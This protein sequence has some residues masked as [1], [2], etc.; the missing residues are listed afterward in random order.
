MELGVAGFPW[1]ARPT[2]Q[3]PGRRV[4]C[5]APC[6]RSITAGVASRRDVPLQKPL[7]RPGFRVH[8]PPDSP[9]T[10]ATRPLLVLHCLGPLFV[11]R[12]WRL[13]GIKRGSYDHHKAGAAPVGG[14]HSSVGERLQKTREKQ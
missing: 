12:L 8:T 7:L 11:P 4:S 5:L 2:K 3:G 6:W 1:K 14:S 13:T 9:P 10:H